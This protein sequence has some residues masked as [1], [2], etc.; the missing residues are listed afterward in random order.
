MTARPG[1]TAVA[2]SIARRGR[3]STK[4]ARAVLAASTRRASRKARTRNPYLDRVTGRR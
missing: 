2:A 4:R 3:L 1:F